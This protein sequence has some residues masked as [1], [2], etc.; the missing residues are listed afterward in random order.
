MRKTLKIFCSIMSAV[1]LFSVLV[2]SAFAKDWSVEWQK[3]LEA[4]KGVSIA[5]G[6]DDTEIYVTWY[7]GKDGVTPTVKVSESADMTNSKAFEGTIHSNEKVERSNHVTLTGLEKGKTYFYVCCDGTADTEPTSFKT[8][9]ENESFSA[10]YVSDIHI[11]GEDYEDEYLQAT[12]REFDNV[13]N[14]ATGKTD[15]SLVLSGGDQATEGRACE[16]F[17]MVMPN[18]LR[19]IPTSIAVGNHDVKRYTFGALANYPNMKTENLSDSLICSDYYFVKGNALFLIIDSTNSSAADHY[20]FVKNAVEKNPDVKWRVMM[21]HHDL[22]GGHIESREGENKLLRLL[23]TPIIDEFQIDLCLMGHSHCYSQSHIIYNRVIS[24]ELTKNAKITNPK[25]TVY[26]SSGSLIP[27]EAEKSGEP[28]IFDSDLKS[29]FIA[30]DCLAHDDSIYSIL[31]F[32]DSTLT[33]KSYIK[34]T[35]EAFNSLEITKTSQQGGHPDED[36]PLWFKIGKYIGTLYN[37]INNISRNGEIK[38]RG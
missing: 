36:A 5:P 15:I 20:E 19:E 29:E 24:E 21:F 27:A 22:Y 37:M 13:L 33:V 23:F 8:V 38:E 10:L 26:F 34:G 7:G 14:E 11:T 35:E 16:Y 12:A 28:I 4:G 1:L 17:A 3:Y 18:E 2:P 30:T 25:G 9:A 6:N 31:D 32:T